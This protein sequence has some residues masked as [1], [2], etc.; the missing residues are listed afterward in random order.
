M[1]SHNCGLKN[2]LKYKNYALKLESQG[3]HSPD[4][5]IVVDAHDCGKSHIDLIF[6]TIDKE[7][8]KSISTYDTSFLNIEEFRLLSN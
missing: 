3:V 1:K 8:W 7:L 4:C 2:Y 5:K 6:C